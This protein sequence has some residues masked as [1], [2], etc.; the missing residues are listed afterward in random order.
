MPKS[1]VAAILALGACSSA[2]PSPP[3][4]M[5]GRVEAAPPA[6]ARG[7]LELGE[8]LAARDA[9]RARPGDPEASALL[10]RIEA[11]AG[12]QGTPPESEARARIALF[13]V[14]THFSTG[15]ELYDRGD[16]RRAADQ[17]ERGLGE[18][19]RFGLQNRFPRAL[20]STYEAQLRQAR[21][22]SGR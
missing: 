12:V 1:L 5:Q 8:F 21:A 17:F 11:M 2:A 13:E 18:I 20:R 9:L 4:G 14:L 22:R 7:L 6:G 3:P 15:Q 19:E 16:F 10:R